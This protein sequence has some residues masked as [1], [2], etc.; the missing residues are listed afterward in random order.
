M[1]GQPCISAGGWS[2]ARRPDGSFLPI[3]VGDGGVDLGERGA[4][5]VCLHREVVGSQP[6][7][8]GV[9]RHPSSVL[10]WYERDMRGRGNG[11]TL[12]P[13]QARRV[14]NRIGRAQDWQSFYENAAIDDMI[15]HADFEN[16]ASVYEFGCGTG[17]LG[18][19][20]LSDHFSPGATYLGVDISDTMVELAANRLAPWGDRAEVERVSGELPL[21]G[22]DHRFDRFVST[23]VFDLLDADHTEAVL[24]EAHR[25]LTSDG[26]A[27]VVSLTTGPTRATR[28]LSS[29]WRWIWSKSPQLLGGCRPISVE[30][31]LPA[32]RWEILHRTVVT[33]W[34]VPSEVV[35]AR[36]VS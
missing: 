16:A 13:A 5:A 32:G 20:L 21:P 17:D 2:S 19:R 10:S 36:P 28:A 22:E 11:R 25:L 9:G 29:T 12:S 15:A 30:Q 27:C 8:I 34:A 1:C 3:R 24:G 14:Y 6:D 4:G 33:S 23:Y 18:R 35:V 31:Q 7:H 26:L